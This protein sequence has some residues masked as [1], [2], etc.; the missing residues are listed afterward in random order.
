MIEG[1]KESYDVGVL[2]EIL[3]GCDDVFAVAFSEACLSQV[4]RFYPLISSLNP[5]RQQNDEQEGEEEGNG[6]HFCG[7][8][9]CRKRFENVILSTNLALDIESY[10][11]SL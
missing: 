10:V 6:S 2:A 9:R 1:C 11:A 7:Y 5:D 4:G 8:I 3:N